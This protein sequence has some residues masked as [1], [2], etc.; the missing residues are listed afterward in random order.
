MLTIIPHIEYL[1]RGNDCVIVPGF[2]AFIAHVSPS[3]VKDGVLVAPCRSVG[4]NEALQHNDGLLAHSIMRKMRISYDR[5]MRI[6]ADDVAALKLQLRDA[7]EADIKGVGRF[8]LSEDNLL[9]FEPLEGGAA[10]AGN[11]FFG[12]SDVTLLPI[13]ELDA[14]EDEKEEHGMAEF[15]YLP[16]SRNFFKI[17]ASV[18]VLVAMAF[19]LSTP[20]SV[21]DHPDYA[22]FKSAD[23]V[24][25]VTR[26]SVTAVAT[27]VVDSVPVVED[28]AQ[29]VEIVDN[30]DAP[31]YY[32]VVATFKSRR[33]AKAYI[34]QSSLQDLKINS[35]GGLYRVYAISGSSY[36]EVRTQMVESSLLDDV[37]D[38]WIYKDRQNG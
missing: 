26:D 37:P 12:L 32:A 11:M 3:F 7:G 17:A 27:S 18:I 13:G 33:Q 35:T 24:A 9:M 4:F 15:F 10:S 8:I 28:K 23:K 14:V 30:N 19:V 34:G 16:V 20:I 2:G 29:E 21:G 6:I 38:A 1:I 25:A 36:D 31:G 5:A 22:G